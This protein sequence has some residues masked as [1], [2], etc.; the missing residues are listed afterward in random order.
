RLARHVFLIEEFL[1]GLHERGALPLALRPGPREILFHGHCHQKALVGS[2]PSLQV[3][4]LLPGTKVT[5]VDSGCCGMAG[6]FGYER[7]HYDLS[8]AIGARRRIPAVQAAGPDTEVVAAGISC[9]QQIAHA[10][11]RR[12]RHLV[13]VLAAAL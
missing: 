4:R 8:L 6:S 11:G 10:T 9:R 7:E 13:E 12:P 3:L 2:A 1:L 5:E